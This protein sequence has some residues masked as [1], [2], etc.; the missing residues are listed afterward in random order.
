MAER[1]LPQSEEAKNLKMPLARGYQPLFKYQINITD[2]SG[3]VWPIQ[4]EGFVSS[5]QRHYRFT[6]GWTNLVKH[7]SI[8]V[9]DSV[10]LE[11]WGEDRQQLAL[12][13][14]RDAQPTAK[15]PSGSSPGQHQSSKTANQQAGNGPAVRENQRKRRVDTPAR[16]GTSVDE[17]HTIAAY[18]PAAKG[19]DMEDASGQRDH[20]RS[21]HLPQTTALDML[22]DAALL[23]ETAAGSNAGS[24]AGSPQ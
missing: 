13:V 11:R 21:Q 17:H 24:N 3:K 4:Y 5:A 23:G 10:V 12:H 16:D 7:K 8:T 14:V 20:E 1:L 6:T 22:H 19:V 15:S 18:T 2:E 9:G